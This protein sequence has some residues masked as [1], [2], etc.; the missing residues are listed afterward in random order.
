MSKTR[1]K[2]RTKTDV[3]IVVDIVHEK[4]KRSR[5]AFFVSIQARPGTPSRRW[6]KEGRSRDK[7]RRRGTHCMRRT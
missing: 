3:K 2:N 1:C 5:V 4:F 7:E 6:Y